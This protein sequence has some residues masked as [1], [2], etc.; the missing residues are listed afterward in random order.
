MQFTVLASILAASGLV[1]AS[2]VSTR[3]ADNCPAAPEGDYI[4]KLSDFSGRKPENKSFNR[5]S[6]NIKATNE[7]T[8][9]FDCSAAADK[10]ED[11]KFYDCSEGDDSIQFAFNS[12]RNGVLLKQRV[13]DEYVIPNILVSSFESYTN[14]SCRVTWIGSA[15]LPNYCR[16]GGNGV[17]DFICTGVADAYVTLIE[18]PTDC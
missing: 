9:D 12:D 16:A 1:A 4:W 11:G 6:F 13:S 3:Q 7:G 14:I 5:V 8:L 10:I 2:P 15:T 18:V 17:N